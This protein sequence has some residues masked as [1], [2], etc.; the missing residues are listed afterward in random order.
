[1]HCVSGEPLF[2]LFQISSAVEGA[3]KRYFVCVFQIRADGNAVGKSGHAHTERADELGEVHR[4]R[5]TLDIGVGGKDDL[6]DLSAGNTG[7]KLLDTEVGGRN[8]VHGRD[9]AAEHVIG[10]VVFLDLFERHNGLGILD[11]ANDLAVS[12]FIRA[13]RTK[14]LVAEVTANFTGLNVLLGIDDGTRKGFDLILGHTE[15]GKGVADSRFFADAG[16]T[17]KF[18]DQFL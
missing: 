17:A 9:R 16:K 12:L 4:R 5:F 7:Q 1:M 18:L 11:N 13:D 3:Q 10:S 14:G 6:L 8:A 2:F 15:N